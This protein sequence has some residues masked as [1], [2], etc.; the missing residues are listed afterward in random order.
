MIRSNEYSKW[1][2]EALQGLFTYISYLHLNIYEVHKYGIIT[3]PKI[4]QN[5]KHVQESK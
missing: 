1:Y 4:I 2:R 5:T 3:P